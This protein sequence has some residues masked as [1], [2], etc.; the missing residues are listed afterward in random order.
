MQND[1]KPTGWR[2]ESF[3]IMGFSADKAI[4]LAD[5]KIELAAARTLVESGCPLELVERILA[6]L[7]DPL[8]DLG[9]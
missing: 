3:R 7:D 6:P 4:E 5:S 2:E 8:P 9:L 1:R